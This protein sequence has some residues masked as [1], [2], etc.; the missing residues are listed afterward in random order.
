MRQ[1]SQQR[2]KSVKFLPNVLVYRTT[3]IN[4]FTEDEIRNTWYNDREM[5]VI[6]SEC[7]KIIASMKGQEE[8]YVSTT[9]CLRGLECV[10]PE[11]QKRRSSIRFCAIDAVLEE[12]DAQWE[13]GEKDANRISDNYSIYSKPSQTQASLIGLE[14]EKEALNIY[15]EGDSCS[16]HTS[17]SMTTLKEMSVDDR[18]PVSMKLQHRKFLASPSNT[19]MKTIINLSHCQNSPMGR[20]A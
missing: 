7:V 4:D 18:F 20:A 9:H 12:Q 11:G 1:E 10:T 13:R 6:V 3:H 15:R 19:T 8:P 5:K 16:L 14:D 2:E 17:P